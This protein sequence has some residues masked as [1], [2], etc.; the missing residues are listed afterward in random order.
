VN[1]TNSTATSNWSL[2]RSFITQASPGGGTDPCDPYSSVLSLDQLIVSDANGNSQTLYVGNEKKKFNLGFNDFEMPPF[3]PKGAFKAN[4]HSKKFIET[5]LPGKNE[6]KLPIKIKDAAYPLVLSWNTK[7]NNKITYWISK[8]DKKDDKIKIN[9]SGS[10]AVNTN[11]DDDL[12]IIAQAIDPC[13]PIEYKSAI[14]EGVEENIFSKPVEYSLKQNTPN[15]FN[16]STVIEYSLLEEV[17]VTL[18]VYNTLGEEVATLVDGLQDAG[19]KAAR[20]DA[21]NLANGVYFYS[22]H[23]GQFIAVKKMLLVK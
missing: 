20:F 6:I 9:G 19:Y 1:A 11:T 16:P 7:S 15:P 3:T 14:Q 17:R 5:V 12:I 23:A 4:F 13:L 10:M 2:T 22:L 8:S 18:K 21:S